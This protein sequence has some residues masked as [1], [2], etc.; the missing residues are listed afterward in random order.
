MSENYKSVEGMI[1]N[2]SLDES[3]HGLVLKQIKEKRLSKFLFYLRCK[4]GL[5]QKDMAHKLGCTQSRISK[6][7]GAHDKELSVKD[8]LD[9]AQVLD[10]R[11]EVSF[12]KQ[13]T[14]IVD[15]IKYHA[16]KINGYLE[17][18][19]SLAKDDDTLT[20]GIRNFYMQAFWNINK[21]IAENFS[22]IPGKQLAHPGEDKPVVHVNAPLDNPVVSK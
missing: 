6:I 16:F 22:K 9:Y 14:K 12:K 15:E 11:F 20:D 17:K 3:F 13:S 1:K 18:L 5:S 21:I 7:E 19:A 4:K 8:L 2:S 10:L